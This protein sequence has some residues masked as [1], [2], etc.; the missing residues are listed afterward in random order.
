MRKRL[1]SFVLAVLMIVSIL[2]ATALAADIV[3]S[4][5]CGAEV[6]W[7]LDSEGVLTISGT[8]AM[9]DYDPYKAPWYGSRSRVK[10][11]VIADGVTSIGD[12]AFRDCYN[13]ASV[14]I[15]DSVTSI[16]A[17]AFW[18]CTSLTGVTIPDSVT[19]IGWSAFCGCESLTS[20]TIPDNVT[21]IGDWAFGL[22]KSLTGVTI[23]DSVTSICDYAFNGCTSLT[24]VTIPDSVTSIGECAFYK[25]GSLTS[26]TIPDSV[27]SI[28]AWAFRDCTSLTSVTIPNNV[29]SIG[30]FAFNDCT[31]LT[32]IWVDRDNNNYSSD[33]SGVLF[34]KDM[35]TLVQCPG[36]FSG[37]YAI[38]DS[39][40]SIGYHAFDS[41]KSLTS[42][43]IPNS[44]TSIGGDAFWGCTSLTSVTI[45]DSVTSISSDTFASCTSLTSVT[46]P[47]SV[48]SIGWSAFAYCTSLTS[49]TI[50][51]SVT[52]IGRYAFE[53]CES[54]TS[55]TI[56]NSMTSIGEHVFEDCTSLTSV[57]IPDSVTSIGY[58]AFGSCES[59]TSVTIPNSVTSI[60]DSVF[61]NCKSL[62]SVAIPDSVTSIFSCAFDDCTSLTDVYYAGSEAQWKAISISSTGNDDLLTANIHY[63]SVDPGAYSSIYGADAQTRALT[64]YGNKNDSATIETNY[65]ALPGVEASGGADKQTT[66]ADGK[67]TLQNDGGSVTFHK[68]GYV[69]RTLSAAALNVSADVYLQKASDYPVINAVW[70]NDVNDVMNTRY[71]MNL[72]QSKRYK[73]EA[74]ISWGS[75]SAKR[76]ILYQGDKSYDIT[77]GASS[78]VLSDRF[79]LSKDL[80]I[81]ATDQK[82]HTTVKKLKLE[83]GSA[84]TA[85]LDGAKIDF[86]DSLKF[87]LP[88]SIP[89]IGGDSLKLG[90]YSEVPVKAVVDKGKVYVAIGYQVA[91]DED[92]VKSFANSAKKLRDNMAK[93][94]T[95]AK[96]CKTMLDAQKELG[97]KAATV[98]GSWGF[99]A[100]FTVMGFAE[101]WYDDD[102]NIHWTDGGI[103]L[104]AN[105]GVDYSYPFAIGP[106]P[107]YAEVGFTADFQAQL[108]LL[109]NADAK[110]FMPSGTLKGDIALDIGAG[111]GVKKVLTAGGG[112]EGK[113]SPTMNFDA[114]NQMTSADAKF[115]LAGY[116]KVTAFGLTYKHKFDP[117]VDKLIWQYPDPADSADL[118]SADGQ[119]NFIDQIY[120]AA[121]YTAPDLSYLEKGSEFFGA[122]KP[123]LFKRLFAPAEFLSETE[124]PVFLSNAYE[125]A[126][127]EL[128]TWD[129]GTMLAVWKG[130]DSKYS[131]LNALALYY[132]YYDGSKWSTPAILEQDGTLDGAFTLQKINGS[133]Y[134]LWQDAGESVSDDITLD[135]L[136]QKMGLNAAPFNAAQQTFSV[137]TVA[138]ASGAVS[139]MPTLCGDAEHL[140]AVWATNTEGDVF[141][142]NSANAICTSTYSNGSWSAA[143]TSYSGLNSIDSLAA[144]YDESG[145]LQIAYSVDVDGDPK[146]IDDME[147]YRNG[148]ALT[149][150]G[151]VDSGVVYRNGTLYWFSN[152]ALMAEGKTVVSA[153]H[154]LMTDRY[155]IVDENGVKAVLFTQNSGLYASLYGIFYD[156][157]SGEWGQPVALTDGNDFV[158]SF[159]AGVAKDG[160]L[161]I[162]ANR[163]QVT[164]TSSDENPY[165]ESSLQLLE[166]APGCQLKITDT[167]YDGGNYLAGEDLPV[168][169]TVT[170][171]GQAA[172]NGVKVQFYDGSKLLYEQT[173]DG[174]LQAGATTT[175][176]ATPAFDKAEQDKALTVKVIPA[177]AENDSTQGDSATITLHQNDLAIEHISWGLNENGKVMVYAD[178]I[179]RGYSTS[180]DVTVSLRK[181]AVDGDV[182]DSVALDTLGTLGLQHV[183]FE[184]DGTD[185]D[186]FYITLDGKAADD[187]GANDA[188]FVVIRK[189]KANVCQHNYEQTT[190]AAECERPGYIIMTCSFCGD[191]YVQKTLAE[192]GHDYLN[193]TCT[194][195]GQKEG[196]TP[197][198]H[199]YKAVV[200][201][202]TCTEKGYTT[203]TCACGDSY[204]DTYTDALGHAW[205]NGKVTKEPTETESGVKTFTC[206]RCGETKTEV[207]P[208]LSHEH[209]YKA[210]VTAPTCTAKGY[211]THTCACG[212]SYVDTYVDAL[213]HAW[214]NGKVTKEPTETETGVKAFTCTR[215]GETKTE[216]IPATGSVDVTEMFTD[217]SHSWADDGIQYCVTHQ[218]MSGIGN[219]LFGPKLTT[220]RAQIVQIL[221]N[222]E[223][224]PKVTGK[225]PFTDLT[226]DWYQD[227]VLWA[228][229]TGVVAGTSSTTF[230]PDLPVT[231]EQIAVILMEYVT[232]V[233]KLERTWTPADLSIFP[234][235][236]S[237][238]DWAKDAMADAVGLGLISGASNGGQTYLEPQGSATREQVATIL[239]E[240][241]KNVKK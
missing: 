144:A 11:A 164:G 165:G 89:V 203:H 187:N 162:M 227:A 103:T 150:N 127:P 225:T 212:D 105:V 170:N 238:S 58:N 39:V 88:D 75:S 176:T 136:S 21:S 156:S 42:V 160:K 128:V 207:I 124:N 90:L 5:T 213:G 135:E 159:S 226:N 111:A 182:V 200:T 191:S 129:D 37:S 112:A 41:C 8:G 56:P 59:L 139:M 104:G 239:M 107:C 201:A 168:T 210:V 161:K 167:Y 62:T 223:G 2:P 29:T 53:G 67:V 157:D 120:N 14:S 83:S 205:D 36:A 48:T 108:N 15:P 131:G 78:L 216:T 66:G 234:D 25:C 198:K 145:T 13:L 202:P 151:S 147:V 27:T 118:M 232:R 64:V 192:L 26:V 218:L 119:P 217:V 7:T 77:A 220:T 17:D 45:P 126:Q 173:F 93:A 24:S 209:S 32:G 236:D 186:L 193:G 69:D 146:T 43:T 94:K 101:G 86:G 76:V 133:A 235:A 85:A 23:P 181:G 194:R 52:S 102:A 40:T 240:F 79:D 33:A 71:P 80:Y 166:I 20:V 197:H 138:A 61:S 57:T 184:T 174:A 195:C 188:D 92:G 114:A 49:V 153:D 178:I 99:D 3:D 109:M 117:W 9:K 179:N 96:K 208:A 148:T 231:R 31:S 155:R 51:D 140:T 199:S 47:S 95:A 34:N 125:Q 141:G 224:E 55:V 18:Y 46:I 121:N 177:D 44:V 70:L 230:E 185:G 123:G 113:L 122:K 110:K 229:Q 169:L 65:Q 152:G 63:Y 28:G 84:A 221:Y 215:C 149:D 130:Y 206:T 228:Y 10:S 172:A 211:T 222:L 60:G 100:G 1:L 219:N 171:A 190:I 116:L 115:S 82:N 132:S 35:T 241:C 30:D 81:A 183:S 38:P 142:Q 74:E 98:S 204:V 19:S 180:K 6:T 237:V 175:M 106:V 22:C 143:E 137:Q 196:E 16:G 154:G 50:P 68:D 12:Y 134:V 73:V 214:D 189:E 158:T 97:G 54:L 91:A 4:G 163:Q 233:L 72:V 87:T